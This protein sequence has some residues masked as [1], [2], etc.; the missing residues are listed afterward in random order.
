MQWTTTALSN[1]GMSP[2]ATADRQDVQKQQYNGNSPRELQKLVPGLEVSVFQPRTK[3]W[4]AVD[5]KQETTQ[6]RPYVVMTA[7][8]S[9][10]GHNR[11]QL[12][13][14]GE[15]VSTSEE[16]L[17]NNRDTFLSAHHTYGDTPSSFVIGVTTD[18][19]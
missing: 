5:V 4:V 10:L 9:E 16:Q 15:R 19:P 8:G 14:S 1:H 7:G 13:L 11:V 18:T 2:R 12:K 6:P 3:T 17:G